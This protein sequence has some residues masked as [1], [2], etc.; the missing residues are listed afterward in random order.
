MESDMTKTKIFA[1]A[2]GLALLGSTAA[3]SKEVLRDEDGDIS[4]R[5]ASCVFMAYYDGDWNVVPGRCSMYKNAAT[6]NTIVWQGRGRMLIKRDEDER[7]FA[8][9]YRILSNN[10][11]GF[12]GNVVAEGN[13]W[14]GQTVRFCAK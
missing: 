11:L 13:C 7:G 12:M 1:A 6:N 8:K 10:D 9:L 2:L 4:V 14:I 5:G 3:F